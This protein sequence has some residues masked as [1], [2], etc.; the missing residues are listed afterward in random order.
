MFGSAPAT[1]KDGMSGMMGEASV[2]V[3]Q[4]LVALLDYVT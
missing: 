1:I 3:K 2:E 4:G